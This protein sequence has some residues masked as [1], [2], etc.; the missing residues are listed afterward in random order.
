[1]RKAINDNPM[2]QIGLI[3][4]LVIVVGFFMMSAMS[5]GGK[6]S[7]SAPPP[8]SSASGAS[9]PGTSAPSGG[10]SAAPSTGGTAAPSGT[11]TPGA[12]GGSAGTITPPISGGPVTPAS[13]I[14][15]PGLPR[16]V[17]AAWKHGDAVV[18]L[19]VQ[20]AGIDDRLVRGSVRS[21]SSLR[22]SREQRRP[23]LAHHA[24]RRG[25]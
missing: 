21:L 18:L 20:K 14:P 8:A 1:M 3:G 25:R 24:G 15:G 23:L 11:A 10:T 19:I 17:I 22:R 13:L 16:N 4:V 6:S 7:S 12:T 9:S 2:V 5:G